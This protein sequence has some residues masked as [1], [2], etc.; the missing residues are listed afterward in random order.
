LQGELSTAVWEEKQENI[1]FADFTFVLSGHFIQKENE[2]KRE[3][4]SEE[5]KEKDDSKRDDDT[6]KGS[7][8]PIP[9]EQFDSLP[10]GRVPTCYQDLMSIENDFP[11]RAHC[12]TRWYGLRNFL[13]VSPA[14]NMDDVMTESRANV[15]LSSVSIALN[16][17]AW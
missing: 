4:S 2:E 12:L 9:N 10:T 1:T 16:N 8:T 15:V 6:G 5:E 13:V 14:P 11:S 17:T 3:G 7:H